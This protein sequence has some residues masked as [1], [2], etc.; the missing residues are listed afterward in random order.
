[1]KKDED[2]TTNVSVNVNLPVASGFVRGWLPRKARAGEP[3]ELTP[4]RLAKYSMVYESPET[5][6][7]VPSTCV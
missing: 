4:G 2:W 3:V 5:P 7:N 1:M 6:V